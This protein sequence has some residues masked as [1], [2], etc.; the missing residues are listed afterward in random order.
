M[1]DIA[2]KQRNL[3]LKAKERPKDRIGGLCQII[4]QEEWIMQALWNVLQN[5]GAETAGI[6]GET[7]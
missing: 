4:C 6:D 1:T 5:T 3:A 7:K 2:Q